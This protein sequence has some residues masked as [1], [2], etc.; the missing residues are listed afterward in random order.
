MGY[1]VREA[2]DSTYSTCSSSTTDSSRLWWS[3]SLSIGHRTSSRKRQKCCHQQ[4]RNT[5]INPPSFPSLYRIRLKKDNIISNIFPHFIKKMLKLP[6]TFQKKHPP[7]E[8][9]WMGSDLLRQLLY[10]AQAAQK[11]DDNEEGESGKQRTHQRDLS[12]EH[13][14]RCPLL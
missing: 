13:R 6:I 1:D 7:P 8:R 9:M 3:K 12:S 14:N 10:Q 5:R 4:S 2:A 11:G